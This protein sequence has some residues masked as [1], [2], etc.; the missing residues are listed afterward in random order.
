VTRKPLQKFTTVSLGLVTDTGTALV[1]APA[2]D[3]AGPV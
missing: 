1:Q 3:M 2:E